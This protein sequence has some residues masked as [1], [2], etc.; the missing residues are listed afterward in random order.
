[1]YKVMF[2]LIFLLASCNSQTQT[3]EQEEAVVPSCED[4]TMDD[5]IS[6]LESK[7][8]VEVIDV[9][10]PGEISDGK[11]IAEALE[12]D[13]NGA[14]FSDNIAKLDKTTTYY[15]Y[16]GSGIRSAKACKIFEEMGFRQ[17]YNVL[18]GYG[19]WSTKQNE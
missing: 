4:I 16:C 10:T 15:L 2:F 9:R 5:F 19:E 11:I 7:K 3:Q 13:Y 1:M 17:S 14:N 12:I 8:K 18:G 6:L